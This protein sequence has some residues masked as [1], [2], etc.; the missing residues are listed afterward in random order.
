[1]AWAAACAGRFG[2]ANARSGGKR[3]LSSMNVYGHPEGRE[4]D[5]PVQ[6]SCLN[7]DDQGTFERP[8]LR[9]VEPIGHTEATEKPPLSWID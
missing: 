7:V 2:S 4:F 8:A 3:V 5:R 1:M 9:V 6:A